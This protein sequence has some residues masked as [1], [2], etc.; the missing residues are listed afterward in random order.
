M[1]GRQLPAA[2][3]PPLAWKPMMTTQMIQKTWE[4]ASPAKTLYSSSI[5]RVL[6]MLNICRARR[7]ERWA[8]MAG[9]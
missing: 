5:F 4:E 6:S 3:C 7:G 1:V 8:C 2:V 9:P